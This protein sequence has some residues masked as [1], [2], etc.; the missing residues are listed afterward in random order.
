METITQAGEGKSSSVL[1]KLWWRC[2]ADYQ[3]ECQVATYLVRSGAQEKVRQ[4]KQFGSARS[5]DR[6]QGHEP[7]WGLY[8][9]GGRVQG[10][11]EQ[12]DPQTLSLVKDKSHRGDQGAVRGAGEKPAEGGVH[13]PSG[14]KEEGGGQLCLRLLRGQDEN[15]EL[16]TGF[17][18]VEAT[19]ELVK[20][21]SMEQ[22]CLKSGGGRREWEGRVWSW[23]LSLSSKRQ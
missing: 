1:D 3:G 15:W 11:R 18:S 16:T 10:Q 2:R 20:G 5:V 19:G 17:S 9:R 8:R 6:L 12:K 14:F 22:W 21:S 7:G 4:E 13:R 23:Q